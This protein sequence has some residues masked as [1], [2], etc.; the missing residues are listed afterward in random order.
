MYQDS[1]VYKMNLTLGDDDIYDTR[2]SA[3]PEWETN[4]EEGRL[5]VDVVQDTDHII[6]ISTLAGAVAPEIEV[7]MNNDM[8]TIRGHRV[9]PVGQDANI[10]YFHRECF[11]GKFSRTIILP[12]D[13]KA[14]LAQAE[15]KN[16]VLVIRIPKRVAYTALPIKIIEE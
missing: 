11:W 2:V 13:V 14:D 10:T 15:Y 1:P 7:M 9:S 3:T 4:A 6:V 5:S 8:L 16:G 12:A